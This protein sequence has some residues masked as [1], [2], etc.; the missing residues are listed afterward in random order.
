MYDDSRKL[1]E[2]INRNLNTVIMNQLLI[3]QK[4][5]A[6]ENEIKKETST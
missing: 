1:L 2:Q 3:Y 5:E 6:I 4:I